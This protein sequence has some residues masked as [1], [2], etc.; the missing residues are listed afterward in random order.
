[1]QYRCGPQR[2]P[3]DWQGSR[4]LLGPRRDDKRY[5]INEKFKED[6]ICALQPTGFYKFLRPRLLRDRM[7][8]MGL[9]VHYWNTA[10]HSGLSGNWL[11]KGGGIQ[12]QPLSFLLSGYRDV[13]LTNETQR[14]IFLGA[15]APSESQAV[16]APGVMFKCGP[17]KAGNGACLATLYSALWICLLQQLCSN[18]VIILWPHPWKGLLTGS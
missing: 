18:P 7:V 5:L 12:F 2:H 10:G 15:S 13:F 16:E 11:W 14:V 4:L 9:I 1:M 17:L 6:P 8:T 3:D